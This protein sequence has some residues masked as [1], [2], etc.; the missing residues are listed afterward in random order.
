VTS[1]TARFF[2]VMADSYATLEPWYAH[3]YA[4]LHGI[5]DT[6]LADADRPRGRALD[7]G[8]GTGFQTALLIRL[9]YRVH[10]VDI[11]AGA[12]R[13]AH[14][15]HGREVSLA[16]ADVAALPYAADRFD[17]AVCC[18]STL[19]F[20]E[21]PAR[22]L[23]EIGRVLRRGGRLLLECEHR[24]SLDVAWALVSG[25]CGDAFGYGLT[26]RQAWGLAARAR[27]RGV[28]IDYPGY[29]PLRLATRGELLDWLEAAGLVSVRSW[30]IHTVTN[31]I[32]STALHRPRLGPILSMMY[33]MLAQVD[34][35]A[36]GTAVGRRLANSLVVL[37]RKP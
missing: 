16:A 36:G 12:L 23:A 20:V 1:A 7:A 27:S 8:C 3:L 18:G 32:P 25:L 33:R 6:E 4:V 13:V 17:A 26:P 5:L 37:A 15:R 19:N 29:P 10:G 22:A 24:W 14:Q 35:V 9:G 31:L 11:S 34:R 30:G 2:D 21:D 28:W